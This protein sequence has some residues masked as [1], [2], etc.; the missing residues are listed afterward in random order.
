MGSVLLTALLTS[1]SAPCAQAVCLGRLDPRQLLGSWYILAVASGEKGFAVEKATKDIEGV[2]VTL[3]AENNL[4]MLSSRHSSAPWCCVTCTSGDRGQTLVWNEYVSFCA[5]CAPT[6]LG[7]ELICTWLSCGSFPSQAGFAGER[8]S[9]VT[10]AVRGS[11]AP[12]CDT[13]AAGRAPAAGPLCPLVPTLDPE[14]RTDGLFSGLERCDVGT[15]LL[16][17]QNSG[18]VFENPSLGVSDCRVLGTDFSDYAIVFTQL[19]FKDEAFST[20]S[21]TV[22]RTELASQE[23]VCLFTRWSRG[24]GFLSQQ[25]ATLQRDCECPPGP[26]PTPKGPPGPPPC[27]RTRSLPLVSGS[28]PASVS[29]AR[30]GRV[31]SSR[32]HLL[33]ARSQADRGG[34]VSGEAVGPTSRLPLSPQ[35]PVRTR[36]SR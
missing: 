29:Q 28:L 1:V 17:R 25:P 13:L 3:T 14:L 32:S 31:S 11:Q 34:P 26:P 5:L 18:W 24:L 10:G 16:R 30:L 7:R 6:T 4:K 8:G 12:L 36:P 2:V 9:W 27:P 35:S 20:G 21:Y 19:E 33:P 15:V 23:A 22:S